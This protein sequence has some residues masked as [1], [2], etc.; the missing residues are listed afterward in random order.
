MKN[1]L[2]KLGDLSKK[3]IFILI[4]AIGIIP[5]IISEVIIV[6]AFANDDPKYNKVISSAIK[7]HTLPIN[8]PKLDKVNKIIVV[9]DKT[10]DN[11]VESY[12]EELSLLPDIILDK[13][14]KDK[15]TIYLV[16]KI[17][18][19]GDT[20]FSKTEGSYYRKERYIEVVSNSYNMGV[21]LHEVGHAIDG[22]LLYDDYVNILPNDYFSST[23]EFKTYYEKEKYKMDKDKYINSHIYEY[24]AECFSYYYLCHDTFKTNCPNSFNFINDYVNLLTN[25]RG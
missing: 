4:I 22:L 14:I 15:V 20:L 9:K 6:R 19:S 23:K 1:L 18:V 3:Q 13:M 5:I 25:L 17:N 7:S 24:F 11:I 8:Q 21:I 10:K 2:K 12:K 16:D